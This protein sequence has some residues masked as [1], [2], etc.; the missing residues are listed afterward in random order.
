MDDTDFEAVDAAVGA[1]QQG[2]A[3]LGSVVNFVYVAD[4]SKPLSEPALTE[5]AEGFEEGSLTSIGSPMVG[6]VVISQT[7]DVV[8]P[9][10]ERPFIQIAAL[11]KVDETFAKEVRRG[12][13]PGFAF[14]PALTDPPLVANLDLLMTVEK[15]VLIALPLENRV[16]GVRNDAEARAFAECL[17][18]RFARFAFP[19]DFVAAVGQLQ[20][21]IKKKHARD[22]PEGRTYRSL[23]EIRVSAQPSWNAENPLI[24]FLFVLEHPNELDQSVDDEIGKLMD[25]FVPTGVFQQPRHRIVTLQDM[26]AALYLSTDRLDLD[27]LSRRSR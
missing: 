3:F 7:C 2:D 19:D 17:S 12:F 10:R 24:E 22:T 20:E 8:F 1:W 18:R 16:R 11:Q 23:R 25:R 27:H 15:S 9:C 21:R 13:R 26:S 6:F 5:A 14:V 4:L